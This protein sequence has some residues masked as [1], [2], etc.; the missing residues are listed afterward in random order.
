MQNQKKFFILIVDDNMCFVERMIG[1][2]DEVKNI[3]YINVASDYDEANRYLDEKPDIVLLDINLPGKNGISLLKKIKNSDGEC[4]V[5][6]ITNH[7]DDY[8]RQ[9]CKDLGADH[10]LD[11]S[12]DFAKVPGIINR[13]S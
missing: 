10:F 5:I 2:L 9:Q 6:M 4:R 3:G 1:L 8:Y 11:K 7:A 13:L 12:N